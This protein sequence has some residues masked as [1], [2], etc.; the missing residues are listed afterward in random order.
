MSSARSVR[1][2]I[3][4][5]LEAQNADGR[6]SDSRLPPGRSEA[7]TTAH[8]G[9]SLAGARGAFGSD[10]L[11]A[12]VARAAY[13]LTERG[14]AGGGWA[15]NGLR[16]VDADSSAHA[17]LFLDHVQGPGAP[18]YAGLVRFQNED[19][20]FSTYPAT[21]D[22]GSWGLSH[23]DVTAA[24]LLA[25]EPVA[26]RFRSQ[27]RRAADFVRR[28]QQ[29]AGHWDS[30]WWSSPLYATVLSL[31]AALRLDILVE[32]RALA[33]Y[34]AELEMPSS[35]FEKALLLRGRSLMSLPCSGI[36][37]SL[38]ESQEDDGSWRAEPFLRVTDQG[39]SEP[40]RTKDSGPLFADSR[41]LF[42]TATVLRALLEVQA[43]AIDHWSSTGISRSTEAPWGVMQQV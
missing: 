6:W 31:E 24:A 25:L 27:I 40:W 8:V 1:A 43:P 9:L 13:W 26:P 19:G 11:D 12:A 34:L 4:F 38:L 3:R 30:F 14:H 5:L 33:G 22:W 23:A 42:T 37:E 7:W 32:S 17:L 20:G 16:P 15:Y 28:Q 21:R 2:A 10:D 39:C 41:R 18:A 35:A 29:P 36:V